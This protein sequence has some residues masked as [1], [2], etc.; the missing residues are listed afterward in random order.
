MD[1]NNKVNFYDGQVRVVDPD[2]K[3]LGKYEPT[4]YPEWIAE[5][6]EPW[7]YLKFPYLKK[8]GWK[9]LVDGKDSGVYWPRRSPGSTP[10]TAWPR[11]WPRRSTSA[12]TR[13]W[14]PRTAARSVSSTSAWR[15]TGR[16]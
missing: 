12:S 2:G 9:G 4:D 14:R 16:A 10:P 7:T 5:H 8:V 15:C 1:A 6:V 3:R 13:P 11:R